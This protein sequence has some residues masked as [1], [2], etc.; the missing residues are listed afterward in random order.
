M[1]RFCGTVGYAITEE[2]RPGIWEEQ[3]VER[4]YRGDVVK[5]NSSR[6]SGEGLNDDIQISSDISIMADAFA[7]QNFAY[8]KYVDFMGAKWK[9]ISVTPERP[10][11][12]LTLGGIYNEQQN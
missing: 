1:A 4:T 6:I 3:I 7:Y 10:R 11:I 5:N 9:V 2:T 8:I 12:T